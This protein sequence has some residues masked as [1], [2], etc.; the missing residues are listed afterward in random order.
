MLIKMEIRNI[1]LFFIFNTGLAIFATFKGS[2][3]K[4]HVCISLAFQVRAVQKLHET[5]QRQR[6][7]KKRQ[8]EQTCFVYS[9][10][11]HMPS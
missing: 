9:I 4:V 10:H 1:F 5:R 3:F 2:A 8:N 11:F 7:W 6:L